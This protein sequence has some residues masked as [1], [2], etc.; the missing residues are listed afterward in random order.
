MV[1]LAANDNGSV[2]ADAVRFVGGPGGATDV[3]YLHTDHLGTPQAMTDAAAQVLWWRDQ[4]PF[5]QTV[6]TGGFSENPLRFPGQYADPE[7][8]L[9]YNYFRDYDPALGRYIQSDPIGLRGGLN[10]YGYAGGGPLM[11]VDPQGLKWGTKDFWNHYQNGGGAPVD[12][13]GIGL[14]EDFTNSPSVK[15]AINRVFS[16]YQ[17]MLKN[18]LLAKCGSCNDVVIMSFDVH[19]FDESYDVT[20]DRGL[21]SLGKGELF[22]KGTC[23]GVANCKTRTV[24]IVCSFHFYVRDWFRDPF[25]V[26]LEVGDPY[27]INGDWNETTDWRG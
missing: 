25:S 26:R 15:S 21:F 19:D 20:S 22:N 12:L 4:M 10:T 1:T 2:A 24:R 6:S 13:D 8:G 17:Q 14:L 5:G 16:G 18:A 7:S 23:I 9:A 3:A 11:R 27:R